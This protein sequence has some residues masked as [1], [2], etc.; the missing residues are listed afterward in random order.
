MP[1]G[2]G[3][4]FDDYSPSLLDKC[5]GRCHHGDDWH[6]QGCGGRVEHGAP[7]ALAGLGVSAFTEGGMPSLGAETMKQIAM[8]VAGGM[9]VKVIQ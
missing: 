4:M 2:A 3:N 9:L 1:P 6:R 8:S 7:V 5:G